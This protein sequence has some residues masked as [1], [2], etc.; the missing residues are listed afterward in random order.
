MNRHRKTHERANGTTVSPS[1][2]GGSCD[3]A[4]ATPVSGDEELDA[5]RSDEG[6]QYQQV[7]FSY[8]PPSMHFRSFSHD[9]HLNHYNLPP[10]SHHSSNFSSMHRATPPIEVEEDVPLPAVT[11]SSDNSPTDTDG[12]HSYHEESQPAYAH[13]SYTDMSVNPALG[14]A[15]TPEMKDDMTSLLQADSLRKDYMPQPSMMDPAMMNQGWGY[16]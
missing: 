4:R 15:P 9:S 13:Q 14:V 7:E 16:Q 8:Q 5:H 10:T 12:S 3:S 2:R 6:E 11:G 1:A